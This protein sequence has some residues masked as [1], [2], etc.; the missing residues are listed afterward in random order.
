MIISL[1]LC[2]A[3]AACGG[4]GGPDAAA[5]EHT[6]AGV[7]AAAAAA[8]PAPVAVV[9]AAAADAASAAPAAA[10]APPSSPA[11]RQAAAVSSPPPSFTPPAVTDPTA[12]APVVFNATRSARAGD[13]VGL[14]G[15]NFGSAPVVWLEAV[16]S[17]PATSLAVVNQVG[18]GWIAVQIPAGASGALA[19]RL[20]NGA[21]TSARVALNAA[22]PHHLDATQIVPGGAFRIFGRNLVLAGSTP[23][24][25]V[26]GLDAAVDLAASDEHMLSVTA[27]PGLAATPSAR[28][29]VDNGNGLDA[30]TLARPVAVVA[31]PAGGRVDPFGLGVGWTAAFAPLLGSPIHAGGDSRL[32]SRMACDGRTDDSSA[33]RAAL[34]LAQRIGGGTVNLPAGVC[35]LGSPVQV[36]SRTVVQ[37]AG[38]GKTELQ[39]LVDTPIFASGSDLVALRDFTLTN[40]GTSAGGSVN[41]KAGSRLVVQRVAI[42]EGVTAMA[43]IFGNTNVVVSDSE[44]LQTGSVGATGAARLD[45]NTGLVF[46][47]NRIGFMNNIGTSFDNVRDAWVG[48]NTWTR[49]ALRQSDPGVIHV[50]TVNFATRLAIVGNSF[51]VVNGAIDPNKNDGETILTEGGGARRTETVGQVASAGTSTLTDPNGRIHP[52]A[53]VNGALPGNLGLVIV[54]GKGAGQS[55]NVIGFNGGTFTVDRAWDIQPDSSSRYAT[56]VWGLER[57]II[58]GNSLNNNPRG[59]ILYSTAVREIDIVGNRLQDNGGILLRGYQQMA[60]NWFSPVLNVRVEDNTVINTTRRYPS[61][62][63]AQF[64]NMDGESFGMSHVGIDFRRNALTAN[65]PNIDASRFMGTAGREGFMNQMTTHAAAQAASPTP[66]LLGTIM[67]GNTCTNCATAFRLGTGAAGTVLIGNRLVD[68]GALWNNASTSSGSE[69]AV[70]TLIR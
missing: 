68:S 46:V 14:Q 25:L 16:G 8:A 33:L 62:M 29:A 59:I 35:R 10:P 56:A 63:T 20:S 57:V 5:S 24:V 53:L 26:D 4:G 47:G 1:T 2:T 44:F 13:V 19:L 31:A 67:Q 23:R 40:V 9:A 7:V 32:P 30:A 64:E 60:A 48:G 43:W 61:H 15:E 28:I 41:L 55:R 66:R 6:L 34:A 36:F 17:T 11:P 12:A 45:D 42:N 22:T 18:T 50:V 21:N 27:P 65:N 69:T 49:D 39:H 58:K 52:N 37:G 54:A 38:K 3:L 70:N 51:N